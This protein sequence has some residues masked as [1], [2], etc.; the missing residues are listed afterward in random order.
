MQNTYATLKPFPYDRS[1]KSNNFNTYLHKCISN[2]IFSAFI[3]YL[4][5]VLHPSVIQVNIPYR[6]YTIQHMLYTGRMRMYTIIIVLKF[7][8]IGI[9]SLIIACN[10]NV[11]T[12]KYA[13]SNQE[14]IMVYTEIKLHLL[15]CDLIVCYYNIIK[16]NVWFVTISKLIQ[17]A[18][19]HIN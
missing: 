7:I 4:F 10:K 16:L 19:Y 18:L 9:F 12:T 5:I 3:I 8:L 1:H 14:K 15:P 11:V 6:L 13:E 2:N 17:T